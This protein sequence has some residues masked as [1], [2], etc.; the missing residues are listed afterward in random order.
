MNRIRIAFLNCFMLFSTVLFSQQSAVYTTDFAA[1]QEAI[2]K[3]NNK[4]YNAAQTL[5]L[6]LEKN[7][8][9]E[10]LKADCAYFA[11]NA[12][13]RLNQQG[14]EQMMEDFVTRY[15]TSTKR[16]SA[17]QE[18]GTYYFEIGRYPQSL[19]W[20]EKVDESNLSYTQREQFYFQI[21]YA[22]FQTKRNAEARKYFNRISTSKEFGSQA[23]YYLGYMAYEGDDYQEANQYFEG[24]DEN[25]RLS[26]NL[27]YYQADMNFKLGN[28]EE[29]IQLGKEQFGKS[30]AQEQSQLSKI[31]GESYFNLGQYEAA[32]PYLSEY[33]GLR[34]KWNNT[35]Y[36]QLGYAYYK[37]NDYENAISE[38]NKIIDGRNAVAQNAYY[39]LGDSYLKQNKKQEAL[40]AFKNASEMNF[41]AQIQ[42]DAFYNYAKLSYE[43]G[44]AYTSV[45]QVLT[46]FLETYP[47][48]NN[49]G[50]IQDLLIDSYISSKNYKAALH[51]LENNKSFTNKLALQKVA[52][53]RGLEL[54]EEANYR[55]AKVHFDKSL[56]EP[57]DASIT[58]RATFWKAESDY[59]L[60]DFEQAL[61]GFK[62]FLQLPQNAATPE[63]KN[64]NYH[65]AYT[66]F[67]IKNYQE[68]INAF[69]QFLS[70][71]GTDKI[72]QKDANLR[73]ADSYFVT[74]QYWPAMEAYNKV[75]AA[76]G[77]QTDYAAFQKAISYGFVDRTQTKLEELSGFENNYPNST[78][79][80]EALYEL[81]NTHLALN[82]NSQAIK[83]YDRLVSILPMSS[84]VPKALLKKGL[85][86]NNTEKYQESLTVFKTVA[87]NY[88]SS[89]EAIQAVS[90]AK[91]IYIDLGRVNEYAQ[92]VQTLDFVEVADAEIDQ[93]TFEAAETKYLQND[94]QAIALLE[95]YLKDFPNGIHLLPANFYLAERYFSS[96]QN[97]KAI[98]KYNYVVSKERSEFS[99]QA[100][101]R[102]TQ[103]YLEKNEF[104]KATPLLNRLEKEGT[105]PQNIIYAQSNLMKANYEA[106]NYAQAVIFAEKVLKDSNAEKRAINDAH[107]IIARSAIQ[108]GDEQKAKNAYAEV[109]KTATGALA[110]EALY[111]QAYFENKDEAFKQ[112]NTTVQKLA[113]DFSGYKIWGGKGLVLMAKNFYALND[114]YQAT[115]I[116]ES[117]LENFANFP[118]ISEEATLE[119][120]KI[121]AEEAKTNA[122]V[123][124]N[125]N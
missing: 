29:A 1:Y 89:P 18:V 93:A 100:L 71:G 101:V 45:P 24:I 80:D 98:E 17:F 68:A 63:F 9:N 97:E 47:Q 99:E 36:Y 40:N 94:S 34:G 61:I 115:Y 53:F 13:I 106:K 110:A 78:Y 39:H 102:V 14:A 122:S 75:I 15:P 64:S 32:I 114:A 38:F 25:D 27:S 108:T 11:A 33:R 117:V 8:P 54:F 4:Q 109:Q 5:F 12:A 56:K 30:N 125:E 60:N 83:A 92:W 113:K 74:S 119:L 57:R 62:Q 44:N 65:L 48:T 2:S 76:G 79:R 37:Q 28:F 59:Q 91:L 6:E 72:L 67:K 69:Q 123:E 58:A 3:Y 111:Y 107:S 77:V 41:S 51:L 87:S 20:F 84:Y 85:I 86:L 23:K 70:K 10:S 55:D 103:L 105:K 49:K 116:L 88:P 7:T 95:N 96:G 16:N 73:L 50:E 19:K 35:D 22:Y 42:E 31:I 66:Y 52:F 104:S 121:K 90:S 124:T 81:G 21:G 43:I 26:E 118:E 112:S 82:N 46:A 120:N